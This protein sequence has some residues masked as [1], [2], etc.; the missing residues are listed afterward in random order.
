M[1][2]PVSH[3][4]YTYDRDI[5]DFH[6]FQKITG[7]KDEPNPVDPVILSK[8]IKISILFK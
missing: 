3:K 4:G 1:V 6:N 7:L 8:L 2:A 5:E